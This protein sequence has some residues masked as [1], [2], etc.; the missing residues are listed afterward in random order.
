MYLFYLAKPTYGGW[1]SFT[2]HMSLKYQYPIFKVG[3]RKEK[4]NRDYGYST[5]YTNVDSDYIKTLDKK[6]III[7]ALD[8]H[9]VDII[10]N[11]YGCSLVIH[12]PTELK[13][14]IDH[15]K[16]NIITIRESV[17]KLLSE[18][19]IN[20]TFKPHP[21]FPWTKKPKKLCNEAVSISRIDYD[22]NIDIILDA[23]NV[24]EENAIKIYGKQNELCVF[25]KLKHLNFTKHYY[26]R[27]PKC[28][29]ELEKIL[30]NSWAVVDMSSIKNDGGGTQYTFL[31]AI[32]CDCLLILNEAWTSHPESIWNKYN[33]ITVKNAEELAEAINNFDID[34]YIEILYQS[35]K[36]LNKCIIENEWQSEKICS[37]VE[38]FHLNQGSIYE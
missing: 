31:E 24:I 35:Q 33:C 5:T 37:Q 14:I 29:R 10:D 25:H 19:G 15:S 28:F 23:N 20:N 26:G 13:L 9:Y 38:M 12:D 7:T 22:K 30:E 1:V 3:K 17:S 11:F 8:K 21:F 34:N 36:I 27:F 18:R 32:Y 2:A 4:R 16:F 6:K